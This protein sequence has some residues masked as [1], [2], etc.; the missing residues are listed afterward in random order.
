MKNKTSNHP[1]HR[2]RAH[3]DKEKS[4]ASH[5]V[6]REASMLF[7]RALALHRMGKADEAANL[8][9]KVIALSSRHIDALNYLGMRQLQRG[10]LR[11]GIQL[12][13]R[14][15]EIH[16]AQPITH[17]NLG[18]A[19]RDVG[20]VAEAL[21]CYGSALALKSDFPEVYLSRGN[22]YSVC[23]R[24]DEALLDYCRAI[25]LKPDFVQ[26]YFNRGNTFKLLGRLN[27]ALEDYD[28]A[29]TLKPDYAEAYHNRAY[30]L[31]CLGRP[32][33]A[34]VDCDRVVAL[35]PLYAHAHYNKANALGELGRFEEAVVCYDMAIALKP[36]FPNAYNN[37]GNSLRKLRR[38]TEALASY[39]NA[40]ALDSEKADA[41]NN[42][43][44][45]FLEMS[46]QAEAFQSYA[47]ALSLEPDLPYALGSWLHSKMCCC[48]WDGIGDAYTKIVDLVDRGE[49]V[50]PPFFLL[51]ISSTP[52]QQRRCAEIYVQD[53]Y[54]A[55]EEKVR[56]GPRYA[57]ERIRV[58]Y[59]SSD[60]RNHAMAY[61]IAEM[62]ERHDRSKFEI[63]ALSFS[64]PSDAP[65]R[66]RL[67]NA[68][69][70]FIDVNANST[71][72]IVALARELEI[73]IA[74]DLNGYTAQS[75]PEI[76]AMR[77]APIQVNHLGYPGTLGASYM[78]YIIADETVIP[79]EHQEFF[80]ENIVYL[81]DTYWFN[82]STKYISETCS[83]RCECGLPEN[84]FVFC[85]FNNAYKITPDL[86]DIWMRLLGSVE[87][88]VLW[89]LAGDATAM[90]NLCGEA[91]KR[92]IS[93]E[94]LIFAPRIDMAGHLARHRH[95]DLF[96]D[97]FY[98]NAH[99]TTSDALWAGLPVIT[100]LGNAFAG[101]VAASLLKAVDLPEMI[102]YD[103]AEYESRALE[104]ATTPALLDAVRQKLILK[105]S[106]AP[107]FNTAR[108]TRYLESAYT[109]MH[110]RH[111]EALPPSHI[112]VNA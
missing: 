3:V 61:L 6:L 14:S 112:Y 8:C 90:L 56:H 91:E 105:R 49:R 39:E 9:E 35:M 30:V 32:E 38:L 45:T 106:T 103:P 40:L 98:Y 13:G 83:S 76:F 97:T 11:E 24:M 48:D 50:T 4:H 108:F 95:A 18:N 15:L 89:L 69:D 31:N 71:R 109:E 21:A 43:G 58:G 65:I 1:K 74:I 28:R 22:A 17:L 102:T 93:S 70:R 67:E 57:H 51:P 16:P 10:C 64:P 46:R 42:L 47:K 75:R 63:I 73:D 41:Y 78:D 23:S 25:A 27:E 29:I 5:E 72:E 62:I 2:S 86:F 34:L 92:G 94:R 37:R 96:L 68:F 26:A 84:G 59:C 79:P 111:L 54:R 99:T 36:D 107:L 33:E 44:N 52:M 66:Q 20:N 82:D 101:R 77:L 85:C 12:L 55:L 100:C 110:H 60:F 53:K 7:E 88:S 87:G 81:P 19:F 104:L 80:T